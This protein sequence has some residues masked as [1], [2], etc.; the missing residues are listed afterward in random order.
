MEEVGFVFRAGR[1]ASFLH[2][3][4]EG[5]RGALVTGFFMAYDSLERLQQK[6]LLT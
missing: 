6:C 4:L 1:N 5:S 2:D 3:L